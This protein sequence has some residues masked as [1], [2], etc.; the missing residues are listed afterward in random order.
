MSA[1]IARR[2]VLPALA[3]TALGQNP[4][5]AE[6]PHT[7]ARQAALKSGFSTRLTAAFDPVVS[8]YFSKMSVQPD[9]ARKKLI[10]DLI[11]GLES[12]QVWSKLDW[13]VICAAHDEQ[14]GLLN[15]VNPDQSLSEN[16]GV[17]FTT[18][19]GFNGNGTS[20]YLAYP[21]T[22]TAT[23]TMT[24]TSATI[25]AWSSNLVSTRADIGT[26]GSTNV[27][28]VTS[29]NSRSISGRLLGATGITPPVS[30]VASERHLTLSRTGSTLKLYEEGSLV[31][32]S[33]VA[34][35]AA[36]PSANGALLAGRAQFSDHTVNVAYSGGSL[37]DT[38]V[39]NLHSR[40]AVFLSAIHLP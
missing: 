15:A 12:D 13:F 16:G 8:K 17:T 1:R 23:G 29:S 35:D 33:T 14:A 19:V 9:A 32:T 31:A 37:T 39:Q 26:V 5:A 11:Q 20:A 2:L 21:T 22:F 4:A 18:D 24:L 40:L 10:A 7:I 30:A 28:L 38:D 25:G 6:A 34:P 3:L 27:Y 36:P